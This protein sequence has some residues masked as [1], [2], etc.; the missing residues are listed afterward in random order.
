M[1]E[2]RGPTCIKHGNTDSTMAT[3]S[4]SNGVLY[5]PPPSGILGRWSDLLRTLPSSA[6]Y[7]PC[8]WDHGSPGFQIPNTDSR[9]LDVRWAKI[10]CVHHFG[11]WN[12]SCSATNGSCSVFI[13]SRFQIF[14]CE[15]RQVDVTWVKIWV[16]CF[17][18]Q[19][20]NLKRK[21]ILS[22]SY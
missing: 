16:D 1:F 15:S 11:S 22:G 3:G 20:D 18:C 21:P 2:W 6:S 13:S 19:F 8:V 17:D 5:T 7:D 10:W 14:T 12:A 9:E 4:R